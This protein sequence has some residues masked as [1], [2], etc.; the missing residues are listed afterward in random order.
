MPYS[1]DISAW[2]HQKSVWL[3]GVDDH[4]PIVELNV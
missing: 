3:I 2:I 1:L 4:A